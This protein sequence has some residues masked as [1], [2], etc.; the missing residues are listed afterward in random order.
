PAAEV[1]SLGAAAPPTTFGLARSLGV[2]EALVVLV[3]V[4]AIVGLFVGLQLA[5]LFGGLD[6]L[7]AAG[8]TYASYARR[9]YFELVGAACLAGGILVGIDLNIARRTRAYLVVALAL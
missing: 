2:L 4:D 8:M 3:A 9:G 5:Y 1:A 6:T 7:A